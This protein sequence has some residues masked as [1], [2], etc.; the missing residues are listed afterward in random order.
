MNHTRYLDKIESFSK[1][2]ITHGCYTSDGFWSFLRGVNL[3]ITETKSTV[4]MYFF[5]EPMFSYWF[6]YKLNFLSVINYFT[7][8]HILAG[9]YEK[10]KNHF[11][12]LEDFT[13]L[14]SEFILIKPSK[15][16]KERE[17]PLFIIY[18]NSVLPWRV[19]YIEND[20]LYSYF[21]SCRFEK[22]IVDDSVIKSKYFKECKTRLSKIKK[23]FK[24]DFEPYDLEEFME[25]YYYADFKKPSDEVKS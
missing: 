22:D 9:R 11:D 21:C 4:G 17:D 13:D 16:Y 6:F 18:Y 23:D 10:F 8:E 7:V 5:D 14:L 24:T 20:V 15:V 1:R 12:K 19:V 3:G 25:K 2:M